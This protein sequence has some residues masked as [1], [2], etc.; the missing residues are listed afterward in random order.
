VRYWAAARAAAGIAEERVSA[1][2]LAGLLAEISRRHGHR[3]RFDDVIEYCSILVGETPG[4]VGGAHPLL[5]DARRCPRRSPVPH[6]DVVLIRVIS[7]QLIRHIPY[8]R[9]C[10]EATVTHHG[11]FA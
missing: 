6:C 1:T 8:C 5:G 7:W 4:Q 11:L 10:K 3:D 9:P 2:D